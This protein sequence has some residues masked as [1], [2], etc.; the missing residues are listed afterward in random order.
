M[1]VKQRFLTGLGFLCLLI[2]GIG[3]FLPVLPTTPFV[4]LA[5]GCFAQSP[6]LTAWLHKSR[7]FSDYLTNYRERT[8]LRRRTIVLSLIFLWAMLALGAWHL[9]ALW[10]YVL[11]PCI[12]A[13]VTAHILYMSLPK[14]R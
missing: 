5:A 3:I 1:S 7:L 8:G 6:R 12:G 14:K 10:A 11:F 2:G 13:G 9:Q 4:L